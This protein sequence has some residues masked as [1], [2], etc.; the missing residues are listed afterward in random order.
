MIIII[1]NRENFDRL[2]KIYKCEICNRIYCK[3]CKEKYSLHLPVKFLPALVVKNCKYHGYVEVTSCCRACRDVISSISTKV[4][5]Y[6]L[7][8]SSR[9]LSIRKLAAQL[10]SITDSINFLLLSFL[11]FRDLNPALLTLVCYF[12]LLLFIIYY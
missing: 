4:R 6:N 2:S 1:I 5:F 8:Q 9:I 10:T 3:K 7:C 12:S 11:Q